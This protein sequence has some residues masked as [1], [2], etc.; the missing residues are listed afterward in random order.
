[1]QTELL[2]RL[3]SEAGLS[4]EQAQAAI[5]V[6]GSMYQLDD[7]TTAGNEN[8]TTDTQ[9]ATNEAVTPE[10]PQEHHGGFMEMLEEKGGAL[11][12]ELKNNSGPLE[13]KVKEL[14]NK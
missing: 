5:T 1:M 12:N 3:Q 7:D 2:N 10:V 4:E 6:F 14:F 11:L 8:A 13:E 9:P